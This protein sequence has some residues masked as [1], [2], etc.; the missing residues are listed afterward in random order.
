M[1]FTVEHDF[2]WDIYKHWFNFTGDV[3]W[4][5]VGEHPVHR[6]LLVSVWLS[7]WQEVCHQVFRQLGQSENWIH[8]VCVSL[9]ATHI[10][11]VWH[12]MLFLIF[13]SIISIIL[14]ILKI[15]KKKNEITVTAY[16]KICLKRN[17]R[18]HE[19][20]FLIT[21]VPYK[22]VVNYFLG[23]DWGIKISSL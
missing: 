10:C 13:H 4:D 17:H 21:G 19:K 6:I 22:R 16:S 1:L 12:N 5:D 7:L 23:K 2:T 14:L 3:V 15:L 11:K 18:D 20:V 8:V 9:K